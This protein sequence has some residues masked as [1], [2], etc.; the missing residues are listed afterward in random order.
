MKL[1]D[2][3]IKRCQMTPNWRGSCR[4]WRPDAC[5]YR[6]IRGQQTADQGAD[7][8][9]VVRDQLR[10]GGD[11]GTVWTRHAAWH[12]TDPRH[13]NV[14]FREADE[15]RASSHRKGSEQSK[16]LG[17]NL[18][19]NCAGPDELLVVGNGQNQY[20]CPSECELARRI[21]AE[22]LS[23]RHSNEVL[24]RERLVDHAVTRD[25]TPPIRINEPHKTPTRSG[26]SDLPNARSPS[27]RPIPHPHQEPDQSAGGVHDTRMAPPGYLSYAL[28]SDDRT[29]IVQTRS[30]G[31]AQKKQ[32]RPTVRLN[33]LDASAGSFVRPYSMSR[34]VR[35]AHAFT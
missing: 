19:G 3:Q 8:H 9:Y 14:S 17:G 32:N 16:N 22:T 10:G 23:L 27:G 35:L 5:A 21:R 12:R 26:N 33:R 24:Q 2:D 31:G 29:I 15:R 6:Q 20:Q 11:P 1:S 34:F 30:L 28:A 25:Q 7:Q 4:A 13:E 18:G